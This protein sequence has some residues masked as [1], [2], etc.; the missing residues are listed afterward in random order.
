[1]ILKNTTHSAKL[2]RKECPQSERIY[3]KNPMAKIIF[4]D[5]IVNTFPGTSGTRQ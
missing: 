5:V 1:M 2:N 4:N 3:T